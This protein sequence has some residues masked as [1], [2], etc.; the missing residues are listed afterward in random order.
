[1]LAPK[2]CHLP[3]QVLGYHLSWTDI[4][5]LGLLVEEM[6]QLA[7]TPYWPGALHL[8]TSVHP[9]S[10]VIGGTGLC[11]FFPQFSGLENAWL[12]L[13]AAGHFGHR[14]RTDCGQGEGLGQQ[15]PKKGF[16]LN[17]DTIIPITELG[18]PRNTCWTLLL[19]SAGSRGHR[20]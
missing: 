3:F 9:L 18:G 16:C 7:P 14:D 2:D 17:A 6:S 11:T 13:G 4:L 12:G 5:A 10:H 8:S 19:S 15:V 1:M 20:L